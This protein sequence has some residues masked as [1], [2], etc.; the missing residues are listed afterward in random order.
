MRVDHKLWPRHAAAAAVA[1]ARLAGLLQRTYR[2]QPPVRIGLLADCVGP[3]NA[4]GAVL[5]GGS[6]FC[7]R[8]APA[9]KA[10]VRATA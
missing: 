10:R 7:S 8:A 3:R 1:G 6:F 9:R 4:Q 5:A 2:V